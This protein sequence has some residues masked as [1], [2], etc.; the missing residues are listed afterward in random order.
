MRR[1][2]AGANLSRPL[3]LDETMRNRV[4]L[5]REKK[6]ADAPPLPLCEQSRGY[7]REV[8]AEGVTGGY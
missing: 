7:A 2:G 6:C 1:Y 4:T 3:C 5:R 8:S